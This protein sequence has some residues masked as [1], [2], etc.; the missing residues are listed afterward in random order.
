MSKLV[1]L[2]LDG[3]L[4]QTLRVTLQIQAENSHP[5][6]EIAGYLPANQELAT[7]IVHHWQEK[8]RTLGS[9]T[10]I[11][12]KKIKYNGSI[13]KRIREC[14]ESAKKIAKELNNWLLSPDFREIN[15][16]LREELSRDE[17][18]RVLIRTEDNNLQKLPWHLWDFFERY[19]KAEVAIGSTNFERSLTLATI[20]TKNKVKILAIIGNSQGID[21][22][23]DR[24]ILL[25]LTNIET[26]FLI[27]KT[28]Q[29]IN[30]Q[31]WEQPWDIIF[32]AGHSETEG[33]TG[34]IYI[35]PHDSLTIDELWYGL[36][37]AVNNGLKLAI[38]NSCDGLGLAKQLDDL[39]IPQMIVMRELVP[40]RVAQEFLLHFLQA[41]AKGKPFYQAVREAR[42]RL[43]GLEDEFPCASWLPTICQNPGTATFNWELQ[44]RKTQFLP[45]I[46]LPTIKLIWAALLLVTIGL[47]SWY[48]VSPQLAKFINNKGLEDYTQGELAKGLEKFNLATRINPNNRA[49]LYNQAWHCQKRQD[50]D[51]AMEKYWRSAELGLPAAYSQLGRLYIIHKQDYTKAVELLLDGLDL[52]EQDPVKYA[53]WKNLGW[54]RLLQGRHQ[55]ALENLEKAIEIDSQR[56]D[57]LCL[58]AQVKEAQGVVA[59]DIWHSCLEAANPED[60]DE[61]IWIGMA[62]KRLKSIARE[63]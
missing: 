33:E 25:N 55:E 48:F 61:D 41:F 11:K 62:Q 43:Q 42:E 27:E 6:T 49:V 16:R 35:N 31:L 15:T 57:A 29:E 23:K 28:R 39:N 5:E 10:R 60:E 9:P 34:R 18:I 36:R 13:N 40:D 38:F 20:P 59:L 4:T 54:A 56:A 22:E 44:P 8:Y 46:N 21:T 45:T 58:L 26:V 3:D 53:L 51:C 19:N 7:E 32:F 14:R 63:Q 24:E 52:A 12:P 30:D 1:V 50:F 17:E 2:K 47:P 37:K